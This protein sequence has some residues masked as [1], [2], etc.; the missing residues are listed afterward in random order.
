[1]PAKRCAWPMAMPS[2]TPMPCIV[3]QTEEL[4]AGSYDQR[5]EGSVRSRRPRT[6]R[7][8]IP[9]GA[10]PPLASL[11][12]PELVGEEPLEGVEARG[13]VLAVGLELD[14][15]AQ[16]RGQHHHAHDALGVHAPRLAGD[17]ELGLEGRGDLG[18][19]G[20]G[21]RVHPQLVG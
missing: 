3:K 15:G 2:E 16:A 17:E 21:T 19:L 4:T 6:L 9:R 18:E 7:G 20:R 11:A 10:P 12:L 8:R 1:M 14:R 13:P 5:R